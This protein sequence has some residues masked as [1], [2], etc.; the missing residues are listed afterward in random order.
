MDSGMETATMAVERRLPRNSRII[1]AVR[2]A[3]MAASRT[4]LCTDSRTNTDWS[5]IRLTF[6]SLGTVDRMR[7][8]AA[9]TRLTTSSVEALPLLLMVSRAAR[10]PFRST[11]L[12][13]GA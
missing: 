1:S 5:A 3:A 2:H 9:R 8:R 11:M 13:C 10:R 12:V 7:G 4:T 6:K